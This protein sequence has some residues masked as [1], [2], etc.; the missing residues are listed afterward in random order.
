MPEFKSV[1]GM[2]DLLVEETKQL[3]FIVEKAR[4]TAKNYAYG[5]VT[6]PLVESNEL[7]SAKSSDEI[8]KR[9][10]TFK[11]LGDRTVS[12][13][14]EFTASIARLATTMLKKNPKPIRV[15]SVGSVYRYDEPQ[16]GR[17]REFWQSNYELIGSYKPEADAEI[18]LLTNNFLKKTGLENY[19]FKVGHIG[20]INGILNKEQIDEK[21]QTRILQF[22][23]KKEYSKAFDLVDDTSRSILES[24]IKIKGNNIFDT[25]EKIKDQVND[26]EEAK[27]ATD[28][29]Q[30]ILE[31][32]TGSGCSIK[33]V[34]PVFSRG[35]EYYTG[36]IFEV[37]IPGLDISLGG[38]GR[39]DRLIE[40]FGGLSTPAVGVAHGIDRIN[41]ALQLQGIQVN[42]QNIKRVFVIPVSDDLGIKALEISEKLRNSGIFVE[43]EVMGRKVGKALQYANKINIDYVVLVGESEL[44]TGSVVLRDLA[45][46]EQTTIKIEN[47]AKKIRE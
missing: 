20:I 10:F 8:R 2:R 33:S 1:R 45:K 44:K 27:S 26:F 35:L 46:H 11:D 9:M 29:L 31:L 17:Y 40:L 39:Y 23:D 7:L 22:M 28:E 12:L 25:V 47:L 18:I 42:D 14:P 43:F 41:L 24:L 30:K 21:T 34:D 16:R 5:E 19:F 6:T 36:L 38:G 37:Q 15:F 3:N 13:R 32:V 4:E